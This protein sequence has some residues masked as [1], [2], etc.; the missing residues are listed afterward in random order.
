MKRN[1]LK[2]FNAHLLEFITDI[3]QVF[4]ENKNLKVTKTALET[5][6]RVNPKSIIDTWKI[7]ITDKYKNKIKDGNYDFFISK[8]YSED[9]SGCENESDILTA[10]E[11]IRTPIREMSK[12]NQKKSIKYIQNLT[13]L[14]E[15]YYASS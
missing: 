11:E 14:S 3:I 7:C 9:I 10:I 4:P 1:I 2:A 5:W 13:K 15:L 8:N 12:A 6:K